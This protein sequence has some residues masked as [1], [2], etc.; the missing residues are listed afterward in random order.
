MS[1]AKKRGVCSAGLGEL[2][3]SPHL[4]TQRCPQARSAQA[5]EEDLGE[6]SKRVTHFYSVMNTSV[7]N[8]YALS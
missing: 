8:C 7:V 5:F 1:V 2:C 4:G 6:E 3:F